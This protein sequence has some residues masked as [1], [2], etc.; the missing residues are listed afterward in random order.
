MSPNTRKLAW[1]FVLPCVLVALSFTL[2]GRKDFNLWDEGFFWYGAQRVLAGD[3]P[4][5]D[6]FA[7]DPTRYYWAAA[8][9]GL[10]GDNGVVSLRLGA[11]LAQVIGLFLALNLISPFRKP[12]RHADLL[13]LLA[14]TVV[15]MLWMYV[16]YKVYDVVAAL[17]LLTVLAWWL[18]KPSVQR[19][20][21]LGIGVGF[22]ATI[23]RNHGV[24][25]LVGCAGAIACGNFPRQGVVDWLAALVVLGTG[26]AIGFAPVWVA[27]LV[28][29][30]YAA[31]FL[32]SVYY[33]FE[34]QATNIPLPV[35][36]PWSPNLLTLSP[37]LAVHG[38]FAGLCF[39]A[40]LAFPVVSI[41]WILVSKFKDKPVQPAFVAAAVLAVP[42]AHYAFSRADVP[43]LSF[44]I[45][46]LLM[47]CLLAAQQLQ[48]T[49][50]WLLLAALVF[51]SG[52]LMLPLQPAGKCL[53]VHRCVDV[54]VAGD[55]IRLPEKKAAEVRIV[56]RLVADHVP[57]G[58]GML[59][60]P[61]WPGAY[62]LVGQK[63]PVYDIYTLLKRSDSFQ[64]KEIARLAEAKPSLVV[65]VEEP[66]DGGESHF[67]RNTSPLVYAY[68]L[69]HFVEVPVVGF[70]T[71]KAYRS[72]SPD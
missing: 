57:A 49:F 69:K 44:A 26:I 20:F 37:G 40:L 42:Y 11:A 24:Y 10:L 55:V 36:W 27:M 70:P 8:V 52:L 18:E 14:S 23:G 4:I 33:L 34:I 54:N 3:V 22:V 6:F 46:P 5:R 12:H 17:V 38:F 63:S 35:P 68:V 60:T 45:F 32:E 28:V 2:Q 71:V 53:I 41:P 29:D 16:Y 65:V 59:V 48:P 43:H 15:L 61:S 47:G 7:Y 56:Q 21:V 64:H 31:A 67:L 30:G 66:L 58:G 50:K 25:G 1:L 72:K 13:L 39:V 19:F 51:I 62:P 9:M